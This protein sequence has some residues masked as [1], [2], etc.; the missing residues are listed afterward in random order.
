MAYSMKKG[1][2]IPDEGNQEAVICGVVILEDQLVTVK[3]QKKTSDIIQVEYQTDTG[4]AKGRYFPLMVEESPLGQVVSAVN[5]GEIPDEIDDVEAFLMNR[6]LIIEVKHNKSKETGRLFANAANA[7]PLE[8]YEDEEDDEEY[9]LDLDEDIEDE[10][11]ED[12]D[13]DFDEEELEWT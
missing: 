4:K 2:Q 3:G 1:Y 10:H 8:E 13:I 9:D 7:Y 5:G 6:E 11:S 12:L